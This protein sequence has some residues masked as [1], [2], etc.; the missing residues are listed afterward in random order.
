MAL[1]AGTSKTWQRRPRRRARDRRVESNPGCGHF[2][3]RGRA[4]RRSRR[5]QIATARSVA[6]L[7]AV[8]VPEAR[9]IGLRELRSGELA[10]GLPRRARQEIEAANAI[11]VGPGMCDGRAAV[12][13]LRHCARVARRSSLVVDAAALRLFAEREALPRRLPKIIVTPHAG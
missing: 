2:S 3:G 1:A 4:A 7:V 5:L 10:R 9:V 11:L 8:S 6:G 13:L 12:D